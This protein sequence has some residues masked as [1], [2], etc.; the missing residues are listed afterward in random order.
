M[1][2]QRQLDHEPTVQLSN[3]FL[4]RL[5]DF[6]FPPETNY[7]VSNSAPHAHQHL[8]LSLLSILAKVYRGFLFYFAVS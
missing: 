2:P 5:Y 8:E 6:A 1:P 3:H 4:K 7:R